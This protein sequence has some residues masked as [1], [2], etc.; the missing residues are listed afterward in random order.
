MYENFDHDKY[1]RQQKDD[2]F[3]GQVKRTVNGIPV[4][5]VQIQIIENTVTQHLGLNNKYLLDFGCGNGALTY[6]FADN[7]ERIIG[8]DPSNFLISIAN[9]YFAEEKKFSFRVGESANIAEILDLKERM[10]IEHILCYG[11]FPYL[12][13]TEIDELF[14]EF[15]TWP[16]LEKIYLGNLPDYDRKENFFTEYP[17]P[18]HLLRNHTSVIGHWRTLKQYMDL[19]KR[20]PE[21][22]VCRVNTPDHFYASNY[23]F[24][25]LLRK[26]SA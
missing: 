19:F 26:R 17:K 20:F 4:A 10:K 3:W 8:I 2:D 12:S 13:Q 23:R 5:E 14:A 15:A 22:E 7:Y 9:K 1:A 16:S 18:E 21:W 6:R 25:L 11:V 24:D